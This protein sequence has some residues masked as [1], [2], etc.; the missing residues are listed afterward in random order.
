MD[1]E[2]VEATLAACEQALAS[3]GRV[4][5][6]NLGFWR[7]VAAVKRHPAWIERYAD[8]IGAIDRQAF[9]RNV[10]PTFPLPLGTAALSAGAL[11]GALLAAVSGRLGN[12][13]KDPA[14]LVGAGL[15]LGTTHDLG[16]LV[17]GRAVGIRFACWFLDGPTRLQPGLKTDYASYLRA[18][19]RG[20]AGM[21]A[22]GAL[23]TKVVPFA[24]LP[25]AAANR[26][27][28]WTRL[29][30]IAIGLLQIATDLLFSIHQSDWKRVRRE[31]RVAREVDAGPA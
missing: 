5:L 31:L 19:P 23:F 24:L 6:A 2:R 17:V 28:V 11:A 12:R 25:L 7:T 26:A 8:R 1:S 18:S 22:A 4:D 20:R 29:S 9:G 15:L 16:H 27:P 14:L 21:H 3:G 10:W 13:W 30:L